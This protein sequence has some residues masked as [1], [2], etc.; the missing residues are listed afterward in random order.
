M[1]LDVCNGSHQ[2]INS[3]MEKEFQLLS[4]HREELREVP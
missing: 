2:L 3:F 4:Y 1:S